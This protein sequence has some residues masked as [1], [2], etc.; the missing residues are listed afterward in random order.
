MRY[1]HLHVM[2]NCADMLKVNLE[3]FMS[4]LLQQCKCPDG[5]AGLISMTHASLSTAYALLEI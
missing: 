2:S 1:L 4:K 5:Q 3:M